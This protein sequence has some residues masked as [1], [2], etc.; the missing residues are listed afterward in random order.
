MKSSQL[1]LRGAGGAPPPPPPRAL[2]RGPSPAD[3]KRAPAASQRPRGREAI[4]AS[5]SLILTRR[6]GV[7]EGDRVTPA[8]GRPLAGPQHRASG[9][10]G[11]DPQI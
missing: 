3:R 11:T 4:P 7:G 1:L 9:P 5:D 2:A 8:A 6:P 10:P